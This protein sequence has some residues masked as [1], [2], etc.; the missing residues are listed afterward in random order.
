[1]AIQAKQ[2]A[3]LSAVQVRERRFGRGRERRSP[4]RSHPDGRA[5]AAEGM[6]SGG[7]AFKS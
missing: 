5:P 7:V 1:V 2:V 6:G 3:K 4:S